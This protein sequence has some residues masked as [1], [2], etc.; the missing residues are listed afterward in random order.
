M[1]CKLLRDAPM[2][3]IYPRR[4]AEPVQN[5]S[6]FKRAW[7]EC[8]ELQVQPENIWLG[9]VLTQLQALDRFE[10]AAFNKDA[11]VVGGIVVAH[12]PW[13]SHVGPCMSVFAQYVLPEYRQRGLSRRFMRTALDLAKEA[14][15]P[16]LAYT[17]RH[18]PWRYFTNYR[19]I[20]EVS[21]NSGQLGR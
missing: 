16:V 13:D 12:D 5:V 6:L 8:V 2:V 19:R 10:V 18:S 15:V 9:R 14:G 20:H 4:A 11:E 21:T 7:V 3:R 17:H 1:A